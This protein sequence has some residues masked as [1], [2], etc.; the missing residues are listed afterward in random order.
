MKQRL[1]A[2]LMLLLPC[3]SFAEDYAWVQYVDNGDLVARVITEHQKCPQII[4]D[5]KAK[6]MNLRVALKQDDIIVCEHKVNPTSKVMLHSKALKLPPE[7]VNRFIVIGDTGCE[8]SFFDPEHRKQKCDPE[9][10]PFKELADKVAGLKPDFVIH[11]GD[12]IYRNKYT[13]PEDKIKNTAMQWQ[14]FKEDFF[15]PARKLLETT[16]MLLMRGNHESCKLAGDGWFYFLSPQ[17]Y[18]KCQQYTPS[19]NL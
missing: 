18:T 8:S 11:V 1:L 7:R 15:D 12:Y 13:N 6:A 14:F 19:Y 5:G 17:Q 10:W 4:I 3:A 9:N 16:P 2:Y